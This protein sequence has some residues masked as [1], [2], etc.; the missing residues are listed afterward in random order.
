MKLSIKDI[1]EAAGRVLLHRQ[2]AT[3][4]KAFGQKCTWA[5]ARELGSSVPAGSSSKG[6]ILLWANW[7][8]WSG[9]TGPRKA[10]F[11]WLHEIGSRG[12]YFL[13]LGYAE[14]WSISRKKTVQLKTV[15][16]AVALCPHMAK[17]HTMH[18]WK[19]WPTFPPCFWI[20]TGKR[21]KLPKMLW[22]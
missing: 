2:K 18:L 8:N 12:Q 22:F 15:Q 5:V 4:Q 7:E 17:E 19:F 9:W 14:L 1:Y 11:L 3:A 16:H 10:R 20:S 13:W 21:T 6:M